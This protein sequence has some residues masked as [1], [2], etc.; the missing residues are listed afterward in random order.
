[1][2]IPIVPEKHDDDSLL[3][4]AASVEFFLDRSP[5]DLDA[6]TSVVLCFDGSLFEELTD[7]DD[8]EPVEGFGSLYRVGDDV[9]VTGDFGVGAPAAALRVEELAACGVEQFLIVGWAGALDPDLALGDLVVCDRALRDDGV[10]HHYLPADG[11]TV[12]AS[13]DLVATVADE[14][15][16]RDE[17]YRV[18]PS[19]TTGAVYRE[20]PTEVAAFRERGVLTVEME[21]AAVFAVAEF[22]GLAAGAAF[23][24]S[25]RL[26]PPGWEPGFH[27][28][29]DR[30]RKLFEAGFDALA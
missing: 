25:D 8:A 6:P 4:P 2:P 24:V 23:V 28:E 11:D 16:D 30:L 1:M 29:A 20:T 3:D 18:G 5:A 13:P 7:R 14:L 9:G 27:D 19:W 12:P 17:A 15:D 26:D 22:R 10:S 21:A